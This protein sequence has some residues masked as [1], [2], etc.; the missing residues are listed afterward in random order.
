MLLVIF[1]IPFH[2]AMLPKILNLTLK[3]ALN[4]SSSQII[5]RNT[6]SHRSSD[7]V[8]QKRANYF[9]VMF[10]RV[11]HLYIYPKKELILILR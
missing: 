6:N 8:S 5:S 2:I 10:L 4:L 3:L 7:F 9:L 1:A 11:C